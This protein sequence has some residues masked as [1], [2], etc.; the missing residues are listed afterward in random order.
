MVEYLIW[1]KNILV[2][3]TYY[4]FFYNSIVENEAFRLLIAIFNN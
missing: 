3:N 4:F 2:I 1:H